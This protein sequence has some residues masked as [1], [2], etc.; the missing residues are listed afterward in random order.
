M[1][2]APIHAPRRPSVTVASHFCPRTS[3]RDR[4]RNFIKQSL[5]NLMR[6]SGAFDLMRLI[7]SRRALILT[8]H[9]FSA[10]GHDDDGKTPALQFAKQLE[11]LKSHYDV[12]P[13]SRMVERITSGEP[14]PP[15]L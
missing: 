4:E 5:L 12:V 11:Y 10:A 9:R 7:S 6:V 8:Y 13:L 14:L 1:R 15:S 3:G 2:A